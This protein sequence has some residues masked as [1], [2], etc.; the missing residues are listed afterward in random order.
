MLALL[1]PV[2]KPT[3]P[4]SLISTSYTSLK[5]LLRAPLSMRPCVPASGTTRHCIPN[6]GC[7]GTCWCH[8]FLG[9]SEAETELQVSPA[10]SPA[11]R[12]C[13]GCAHHKGLPC[14]PGTEGRGRGWPRVWSPAGPSPA[15]R[16]PEASGI[17]FS[18]CFG[19][20]P[21]FSPWRDWHYF[22]QGFQGVGER[23]IFLCLANSLSPA[24]PPRNQESQKLKPEG[25]R[26]LSDEGPRQQMPVEPGKSSQEVGGREVGSVGE[27]T[28]PW[29]FSSGVGIKGRSSPGQRAQYSEGRLGPPPR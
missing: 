6:Q 5:A 13:S 3:Q 28:G 25:L 15:P 20:E 29:L 24:T 26:F 16:P 18:L 23:F 8:C 17:V 19:A 21:V 9:S 2:G 12:S 4:R 11:R 10:G 1:S 22:P 27:G 14:P 7:P